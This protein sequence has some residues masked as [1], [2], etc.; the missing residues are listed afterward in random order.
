MRT[1]TKKSASIQSRTS[2]SK[3][4]GDSIHFFITLLS[5]T[6]L[7]ARSSSLAKRRASPSLCTATRTTSRSLRKSTTSDFLPLEMHSSLR[8]CIF[9]KCCQPSCLLFLPRLFQDV[10]HLRDLHTESGQILQSSFSAVS[11]AIFEKKKYS[12]LFLHVFTAIS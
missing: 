3:F 8:K 7:S 4:G 2:L 11:K 9:S 5:T 6:S 1:W 10:A 12:Q